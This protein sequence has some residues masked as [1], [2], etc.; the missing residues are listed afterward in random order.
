MDKLKNFDINFCLIRLVLIITIKKIHS[1]YF[2]SNYYYTILH[3]III[4]HVV[5][6]IVFT[7]YIIEN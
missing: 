4:L 6:F 7:K 5:I 1:K 3:N 2:E